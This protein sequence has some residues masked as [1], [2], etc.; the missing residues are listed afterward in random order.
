MQANQTPV[1][2]TVVIAAVVLLV[3]GLFS[4]VGINSNLKL[5]GEKLDGLDIDE[6][7]LAN[8]IVAGIVIPEVTIPEVDTKKVDDLW[9]TLFVDCIDDLKG[10]V[11]SE[12]LNI[13]HI[14]VVVV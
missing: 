3:V 13:L 1:V 7:A 10:L 2:W 6:T 5:V 8:A 12:N 11:Y 4:A 14:I 9:Q